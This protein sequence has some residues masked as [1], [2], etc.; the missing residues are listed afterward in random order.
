MGGNDTLSADSSD[1][2]FLPH[3][4]DYSWPSPKLDQRTPNLLSQDIVREQVLK[5]CG[6][7]I[8]GY[9][10]AIFVLNA[11]LATRTVEQLV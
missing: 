10:G 5:P 11:S 3:S 7:V 4:R 8:E 1:C 2:L 9:S 6:L